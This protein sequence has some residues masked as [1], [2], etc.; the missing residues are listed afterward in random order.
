LKHALTCIGFCEELRIRTPDLQRL[1]YKSSNYARFIGDY[2]QAEQLARKAVEAFNEHTADEHDY[3]RARESLGLALRRTSKFDEAIE[4]LTENLK[5]QEE[6][7]EK[8]DPDTLTTLNELGWAMFLKGDAEGAEPRL[9]EAKVRREHRLTPLAGATQH[10][11]QNLA[12]C[13]CRLGK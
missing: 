9:R 7:L 12:A 13:L 4:I 6:K 1:Y 11:Y 10:T 2:P 3:F 5:L 8:D